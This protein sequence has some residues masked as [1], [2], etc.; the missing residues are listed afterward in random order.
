MKKFMLILVCFF[1]NFTQDIAFSQKQPSDTELI[2]SIILAERPPNVD[3][4]VLIRPITDLFFFIGNVNSD[5]IKKITNDFIISEKNIDC[6]LNNLIAQL[7]ER[8]KKPFPLNIKSDPSNGYIV[9]Y[10]NK[11]KNVYT[12][13]DWGKWREKNPRISHIVQFS[14]PAYDPKSRLILIYMSASSG[15]QMAIGNLFLYRYEEG[16]AIKVGSYLAWIS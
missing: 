10:S 16:K 14:R 11:F 8:N 7:V 5:K 1:C 12:V 9:D 6:D 3:E 13:E 2:I 4:L 15:W